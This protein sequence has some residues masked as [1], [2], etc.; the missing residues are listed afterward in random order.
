[1]YH[2]CTCVHVCAF[3]I[4]HVYT[5]T[6]TCFYQ[7]KEKRNPKRGNEIEGGIDHVNE[8]ET[9]LENGP[10]KEITTGTKKGETESIIL[11]LFVWTLAC[12]LIKA[13]KSGFTVYCP[14][15]HAIVRTF[16]LIGASRGLPRANYTLHD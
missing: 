2:T 5:C 15:P 7:R 8:E 1:M 9:D 13:R 11:Y 12:C 6:C 10:E 3:C 4:I 16:S 14:C